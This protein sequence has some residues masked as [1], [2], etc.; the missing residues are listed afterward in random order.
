VVILNVKIMKKQLTPLFFL[1]MVCLISCDEGDDSGGPKLTNTFFPTLQ[2]TSSTLIEGSGNGLTLGLNFSTAIKPGTVV[3]TIAETGVAYGTNYTTDPA[4]SNGE[5]AIAYEAGATSVSF[6]LSIIDDEVLSGNGTLKIA[7]KEVQSEEAFNDFSYAY[8]LTIVDDEV[9]QI[10]L[11]ATELNVPASVQGSEGDPVELTF[12]KLNISGDVTATTTGNF[13]VSNAVDGTYG[14]SAIVSGTSVFVKFSAGKSDPLGEVTGETLTLK[15]N[16][17]Q[18]VTVALKSSVL[19]NGILYFAEYFSTDPYVNSQYYIPVRTDFVGHPNMSDYPIDALNAWVMGNTNAVMTEKGG[20]LSLAGY[21]GPIEGTTVASII[22]DEDQGNTIL[23]ATDCTPKADRNA[24]IS[25]RF[26]QDGEIT[27]GTI[28]LGALVN[29]EEILDDAT[30]QES[31]AYGFGKFNTAGC[32]KIYIRNDGTTSKFHVG[33]GVNV[34]GAQNDDTDISY[35][36]GSYDINKTY[37]IIYSYT[38]VDGDNN[39]ILKLWVTDSE[40]E[41]SNLGSVTPTLEVVSNVDLDP[42]GA[43]MNGFT[44]FVIREKADQAGSLNRFL[45][46]GIRVATTFSALFG[47]SPLIDSNPT[48]PLRD[49]KVIPDECAGSVPE[50]W[51]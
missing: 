49:A 45:I 38:F 26:A 10:N 9:A 30:V 11:S 47:S 31:M 48:I 34:E 21:P 25:R 43:G 40:S 19:D 37:A 33:V 39:D 35:T 23:K 28:I 8:T 20:A 22:V 42:S 1:F 13:K 32:A 24:I 3:F 2:E 14:S 4:A 44:H 5:I 50:G 46:S 29:V 7:F 17:A 51:R 12:E 18:D 27:S 6:T 15:A 41:L 16:G 36:S